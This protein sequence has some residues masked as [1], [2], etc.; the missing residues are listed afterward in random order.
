MK[1]PSKLKL[2]E[3]IRRVLELESHMAV[4]A[5]NEVLKNKK[6]YPGQGYEDWHAGCLYARQ[7]AAADL[8]C[9][10]GIA[11]SIDGKKSAEMAREQFRTRPDRREAYREYYPLVNFDNLQ[12][13][14]DSTESH[15][16]NSTGSIPVPAT[17]L[18]A[19]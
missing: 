7:S 14:L 8:A 5:Y 1:E 13:E 19:A 9:L 10:L 18:Q 15:K 6:K 2:L 12:G 11:N 16:L 3:G 17:T 4:H